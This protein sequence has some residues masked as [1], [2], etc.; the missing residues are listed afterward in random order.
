MPEWMT[1]LEWLVWWAAIR[2]SRSST[3]T[4][5]PVV[6][7]RAARARPRGRRSRRRPRRSRT[8][9]VARRSSHACETSRVPLPL[10]PADRAPARALAQDDPRRARAGATS[11]STT[12]SARSPSSTATSSS[13]SRGAAGRSARYFPELA[14]PRGPVR[15]RRRAGD[16]RRRRARGVRRA[17]EPL[18]P[19]ESR[20]EMLAEKTPALFR[21]FDLLAVGDDSAA[22]RPVQ[23]APRR[24]RAAR[25]RASTTRVGR[26][27]A[28]GRRARRGR[29]L[30]ARAARA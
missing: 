11:P 25:R 3:A 10:K 21:A 6:A 30:A 12:A 26:A 17:P 22:R 9:E 29:A 14:L 23:R 19:A 2:G 8:R 1:P 16:P 7:Q 20:V 27:D 5:E 13:C 24:A 15:A 4:R 28:A 18:H